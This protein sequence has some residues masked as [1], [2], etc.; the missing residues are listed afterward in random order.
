MGPPCVIYRS[1]SE[2]HLGAKAQSVSFLPP[3]TEV[4]SQHLPA[5]LTDNPLH[6]EIDIQGSVGDSEG[7]P[8]ATFREW[9]SEV[10]PVFLVLIDVLN[11]CHRSCKAECSSSL[12][13]HADQLRA[14][15]RDVEEW[16]RIHPC[17]HPDLDLQLGR[18]ASTYG[19]F[20]RSLEIL[21]QPAP[22]VW[23]KVVERQLAGLHA[24]IDETVR[25]MR[26][27]SMRM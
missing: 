7:Q 25:M 5:L 2:D 19:Y 16:I 3:S 15:S 9:Q 27:R 4:E 20:G 23:W 22:N 1:P 12:G 14:A 13:A 26:G 24:L 17:P 6:V 18:V 8:V 11:A 21:A 10:G